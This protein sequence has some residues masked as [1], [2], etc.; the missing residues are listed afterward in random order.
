M[1]HI[2]PSRYP[3]INRASPHYDPENPETVSGPPMSAHMHAWPKMRP[4]RTSNRLRRFGPK[5]SR[6]TIGAE[7]HGFRVVLCDVWH[8]S[9]GADI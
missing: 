6:Q 5:A 2:V 9:G 4:I 1:I 8:L 3:K 7:L